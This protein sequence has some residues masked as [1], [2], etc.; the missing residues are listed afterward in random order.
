MITKVLPFCW[1]LPLWAGPFFEI[2][3]VDSDTGRGV[4]CIELETSNRLRFV[5]DSA[6]RIAYQEPG[7]EN[8]VVFFHTRGHGYEFSKDGFGTT[9]VRLKIRPGGQEVIRARRVNLAERLYRATGEGIYRDTILLGHSAPTAEPLLNANVVGQDSIQRA[10]FGGKIHWFWGDTIPI[11]YPLGNF[12]MTGATSELPPQGGLDPAL[13]I[14]YRYFTNTAHFTKEMFPLE[15]KGDLIWADGFLV[16]TNNPGEE[17][18]LAHFQRLKGLGKPTGRGLAI[19]D[20]ASDE[21]MLL[22][23]LSLEETWR[24]PHGHPIRI[25]NHFLFGGSFPNA[26]V[27]AN[28]VAIT[29]AAAYEAWSCLPDGGGFDTKSVVPYRWTK[30][31]PPV[32]AKEEKE[33]IAAGA[34]RLEQAHFQPR[35][36]ESG[37]IVQMHGGSV[38]WNPW[39][40]KWILIAV[41]IGGSSMLGEIWYSEADQPTGPWRAARKVVTHDQ[42]SF[43]NPAHHPFFDQE[44]G[45]VIFFEGT[46]TAEFSGNHQPTPRY[47]YN[48]I[49]YRLDLAKVSLEK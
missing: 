18:M 27:P 32:G 47:D 45:R 46:Y 41:E 23:E 10:I 16:L 24:F 5:T 26:R 29:N 14:N 36:V 49:V 15:P 9:G 2:Q 7:P 30:D 19:Y 1:C 28:F 31:A 37:N 11:S 43:Y 35:D 6:G 34:M 17:Q 12:R 3:V 13:G 8:R 48:Q 33:L 38:S 40:K 4:P 44:G 22:K 20:Q 39:R 25:G 42:Y 21:F